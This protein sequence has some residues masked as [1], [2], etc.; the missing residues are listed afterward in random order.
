MKKKHPIRNTILIIFAVILLTIV[1]SVL[2][3]LAKNSLTSNKMKKEL[4]LAV[5]YLEEMDYE[6]AVARFENSL[7][8]DPSNIFSYVG[9]AL[10]YEQSGDSNKAREILTEGVASTSS[11]LL[12]VV[13]A[14][15]D[16]GNSISSQIQIEQLEKE[17][18]YEENPFDEF[19]ILGTNFYEWDFMSL[20]QLIGIK[21][22]DY[23]GERVT[24]D[25]GDGISI[26][27]DATTEDIA[28]ELATNNEYYSY[29]YLNGSNTQ[30]IKAIEDENGL[31]NSIEQIQLPII[32]GSTL[33][34]AKRFLGIDDSTFENNVFYLADS[35]IGT[36]TYMIYEENGGTILSFNL[37]GAA[38]LNV[39]LRFEGDVLT[40]MVLS[41]GK[42][43]N[44]RTKVLN[45][46]SEKVDLSDLVMQE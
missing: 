42:P 38:Q 16:S 35:S 29:K 32:P 27:F 19:K 34:E 1:S 11:V 8:I 41:F 36:I 25:E 5:R 12:D 21:Y 28:V 46:V 13:L 3:A 31:L 30:V 37:V 14:S 7:E 24:I 4:N 9:A 15:A 20:L 22:E 17:L 6:A 45:F 43:D 33:S 23:A 40:E 44:L 18:E 10:A 26:L 2:F 39:Q